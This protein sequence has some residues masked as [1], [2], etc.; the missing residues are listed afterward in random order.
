MSRAEDG[1]RSVIGRRGERIR[2]PSLF[3]RLASLF[4]RN[5][6]LL[7]IVPPLPHAER[8][9]LA[10][11]LIVRNAAPRLREWIEFHLLGGVGHFYVYDDLSTDGTADVFAPYVARGLATVLPWHVSVVD[12]ESGRWSSQQ[13]IAYAHAMQTFGGGWRHM[14]FID[15][16]EFLVPSGERDLPTVLADL[17]HPSNVSLPWHMFGFNGHEVMPAGTV[18][19]NYTRRSVMTLDKPILHFKCIVDPT[20]VVR[21]AIHEF[22]T[23]DLGA[24][25]MNTVGR[26]IDRRKRRSHDFLTSEGIQL[27]HYFTRSRAELNEKIE[28]GGSNEWDNERNRARILRHAEAIERQTVEDRKALEFLAKVGSIG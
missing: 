25:S 27:N 10:I 18:V 14:A 1:A 6:G 9:D 11:V 19:E 17:G 28:R 23:T 7:E 8:G 2:P 16:D 26:L 13:I 21:V 20:K 5:V 22:E 24:L 3:R 15:D 12:S 4:E